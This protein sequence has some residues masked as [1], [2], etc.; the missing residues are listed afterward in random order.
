MYALLLYVIIARGPFGYVEKGYVPVDFF[1]WE[2][3]NHQRY[4]PLDQCEALAIAHAI[5]KGEYKCLPS[6]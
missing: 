1:E 4:S 3:Y 2:I 6:V 5:P